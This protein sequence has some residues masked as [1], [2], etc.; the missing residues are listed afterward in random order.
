MGSGWYQGNA[1]CPLELFGLP[2]GAAPD[3]AQSHLAAGR[4]HGSWGPQ[5]G[6]VAPD[7]QPTV[8]GRWGTE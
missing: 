2:I 3:H 1:D 7:R 5:A 4:V 8:W 6:L